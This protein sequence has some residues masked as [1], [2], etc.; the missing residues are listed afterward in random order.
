MPELA[1]RVEIGWTLRAAFW[2]RGLASEAAAAAVATCFAAMDD[3]GE[4]I[5]LIHP[6]NRRSEAVARRPGMHHARDVRHPELGEDLRVY[7]IA[8]SAGQPSV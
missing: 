7:A 6:A 3:I 4:L 8:R 1:D 5:S 2:G